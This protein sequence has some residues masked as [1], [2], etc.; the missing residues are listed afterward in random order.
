MQCHSPNKKLGLDGPVQEGE[1]VDVGD[2]GGDVLALQRL[3]GGGQGVV[4][5]G[6]RENFDKQLL[7]KRCI[8]SIKFCGAIEFKKNLHS[9]F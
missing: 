7:K 6:I 8:A 1:G 9:K 5:G 4:V 3:P 2:A